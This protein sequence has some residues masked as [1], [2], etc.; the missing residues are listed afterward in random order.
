MRRKQQARDLA[1][2]MCE[3]KHIKKI[4]LKEPMIGRDTE[5]LICK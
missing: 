4:G 1:R 3:K 5:I 2:A